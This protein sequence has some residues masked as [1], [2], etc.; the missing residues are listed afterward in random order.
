MST[1]QTRDIGDTHADRTSHG[2]T[3]WP[4][5]AGLLSCSS[6]PGNKLIAVRAT[7]AGPVGHSACQAVDPRRTAAQTTLLV[8]STHDTTHAA[9]SC[10]LSHS[11]TLT[12]LPGFTHTH[13]L[14]SSLND[15]RFQCPADTYI[16]SPSQLRF[17]PLPRDATPVAVAVQCVCLSVR[18]RLSQVEVLS[19]WSNVS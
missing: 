18:R 6:C 9:R 7:G 17:Q 19:R 5:A 4:T 15:D 13:S 3:D 16:S 8:C 1:R 10:S 2:P 14:T 12:R 11:L